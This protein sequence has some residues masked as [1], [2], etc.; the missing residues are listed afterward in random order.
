MSN[1]RSKLPR[2][3]SVVLERVD[4]LE[5]TARGKTPFV[6]HRAPVK[7]HLQRGRSHMTAS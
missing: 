6:I 2:S 7:E 1:V 5:R 4:E 3:M